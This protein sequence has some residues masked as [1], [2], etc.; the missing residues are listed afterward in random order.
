MKF[1]AINLDDESFNGFVFEHFTNKLKLE[2]TT[3]SFIK[4]NH[5]SP[6]LLNL[7][8]IKS[9]IPLQTE[10]FLPVFDRRKVDENYSEK[11]SNR[12]NCLL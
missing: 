9:R 6:L 11:N 2:P 10:F 12:G 3:L 8:Q 5:L 4:L 1:R 7:Y